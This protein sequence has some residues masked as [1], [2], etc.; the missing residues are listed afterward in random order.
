MSCQSVNQYDVK[1]LNKFEDLTGKQPEAA[2][3]SATTC[4]AM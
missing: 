2:L 1:L 3:K 4:Y